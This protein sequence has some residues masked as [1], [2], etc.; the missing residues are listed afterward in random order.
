MLMGVNGEERSKGRRREGNIKRK[1]KA[2]GQTKKRDKKK[3]RMV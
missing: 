2:K 3:N 1:P